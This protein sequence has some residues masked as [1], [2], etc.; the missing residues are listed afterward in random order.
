MVIGESSRHSTNLPEI[1]KVRVIIGLSLLQIR[2]MGY[3]KVCKRL[4]TNAKILFL[5]LIKQNFPPTNG[6]APYAI[7][8]GVLSCRGFF[9]QDLN[10]SSLFHL[11]FLRCAILPSR[12]NV[13][14]SI[15]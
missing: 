6:R 2:Y 10:S 13:R 9:S 14:S 11:R 4:F 12:P 3:R 15:K 7:R 1:M 8:L 5:I